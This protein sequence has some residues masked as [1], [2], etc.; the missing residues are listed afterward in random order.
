MGNEGDEEVWT[1][2][3]AAAVSWCMACPTPA[4]SD[5]AGPRLF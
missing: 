1:L 2:P 4:A 5:P 3:Q